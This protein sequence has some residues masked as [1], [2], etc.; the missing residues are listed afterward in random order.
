MLDLLAL[1]EI[2]SVEIAADGDASNVVVIL[3][4][5]SVWTGLGI[6]LFALVRIGMRLGVIIVDTIFRPLLCVG[7]EGRLIHRKQNA[8]IFIQV[9]LGGG[10]GGSESTNLC[11]SEFNVQQKGGQVQVIE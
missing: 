10:G 5:V 3:V 4:G 1:L 8:F 11:A 7:D 2:W 9:L 6:L